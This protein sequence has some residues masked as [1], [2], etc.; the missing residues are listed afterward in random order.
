MAYTHERLA[1]DL[2]AAVTA[3]DRKQSTKRCFNAYALAQYL[4]GTDRVVEAVT[5]G[6]TVRDAVAS[7]FTDRL[8]DNILKAMNIPN[9]S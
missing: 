5:A 9:V 6:L 3:Y 7:V 2:A 1:A 4:R 8:R